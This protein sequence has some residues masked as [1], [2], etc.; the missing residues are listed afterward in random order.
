LR[1]VG[2]TSTGADT[3]VPARLCIHTALVDMEGARTLGPKPQG[4]ML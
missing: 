2:T 3:S 4:A 1:K